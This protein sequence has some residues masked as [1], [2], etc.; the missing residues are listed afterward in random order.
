MVQ[1]LQEQ[2]EF[3]EY[4]DSILD[5]HLFMIEVIKNRQNIMH[6]LV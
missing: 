5:K 2:K 3:F 4:C 6:R 1:A